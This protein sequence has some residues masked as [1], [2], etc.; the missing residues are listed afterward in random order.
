MWQTS[1]KKQEQCILTANKYKGSCIYASKDGPDV[2]DVVACTWV[3]IA[4]PAI[5]FGCEMIPFSE[6]TIAV[7]D[8]IQSEGRIWTPE[9]GSGVLQ[10]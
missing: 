5:L 8:K 10:I 9:P 4:I 6:E 7:I 1:L 3:N 2:V